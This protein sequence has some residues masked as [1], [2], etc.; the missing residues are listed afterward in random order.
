LFYHFVSDMA[1]FGGD[2]TSDYHIVNA[3]LA[4][5]FQLGGKQGS[6]EVVGQNLAGDYFDFSN[7]VISKRKLFIGVRVPL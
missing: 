1:W 2:Q 6:V 7:K 4:R 3:R 5:T